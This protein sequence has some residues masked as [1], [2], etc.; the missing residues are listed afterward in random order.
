M[1][2]Q[3]DLKNTG[4]VTVPVIALRMPATPEGDVAFEYHAADQAVPIPEFRTRQGLP[5]L[6]Q[7]SSMTMQLQ[8]D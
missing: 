7:E 2:N 1:L 8:P 3:Q 6:L 5:D 4:N